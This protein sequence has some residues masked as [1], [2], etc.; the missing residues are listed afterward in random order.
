MSDLSPI[1]AQSTNWLIEQIVKLRLG[2]TAGR[3]SP[4]K[5]IMLLAVLDLAEDGLLAVNRIYFDKPLLSRFNKYFAI[6]AIEGDWNQPG[7]PFFHLRSSDFWF[8]RVKPGRERVY[9]KLTRVGWAT[10][11][12]TENIEY[13]Y[14][15]D[16]AFMAMNDSTA[17]IMLYDAIRDRLNRL[18][19]S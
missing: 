4:H 9:T 3:S 13:A 11:P 16:R 19:D 17:R 2:R 14:L 18:F 5:L 8:H 7:M 1:V 6:F 10:R 15:D 12:I